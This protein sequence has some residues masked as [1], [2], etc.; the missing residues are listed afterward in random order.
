MV[1]VSCTTSAG[2]TKNSKA[3][4]TSSPKA[5]VLMTLDATSER[6]I[7]WRMNPRAIAQL[8]HVSCA[9]ERE[10]SNLVILYRSSVIYP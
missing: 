1:L 5:I 9:V 2:F 7:E 6:I 10:G 4:A 8:K 3:Y